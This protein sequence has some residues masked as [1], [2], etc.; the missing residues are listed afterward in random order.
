MRREKEKSKEEIRNRSVEEMKRV[1]DKKCN[2]QMGGEKRK[3][4]RR[5]K[6][7]NK[8]GEEWKI[9]MPASDQRRVT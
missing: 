4:K 6:Q 8:K 7:R 1:T 9:R 2:K 5:G 3:D